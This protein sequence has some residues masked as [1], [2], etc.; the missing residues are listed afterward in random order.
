M[1]S[2]SSVLS[3][4]RLSI[5]PI[6]DHE[7]WDLY[8]KHLSS[9]W[10]AEECD[11]GTDYKDFQKMKPGE[12]RFI[13]MVL[14]FFNS[15]D[16]IVNKNLAANFLNEPEFQ[17]PEIQFFY[18]FQ[19]MMENIHSTTYS[20]LID[21]FFKDK[22]E[23]A[24][25]FDAIANF[26]TIRAKAEWVESYMNRDK[27][28][29]NRLFGFALCEGLSFSGS[30]C[31]IYWLKKRNLCHGLTFTNELISKDEGLHT[32]FSCLMFKRENAKL[33]KEKRMTQEEA[34]KIT[35]EC[36]EVENRFVNESL[37]ISLIGM[38]S[39]MMRQYIEF[40]ADFICELA[41]FE[42]I[43]GTQN[44]FPFMEMIS[45]E[46]RTNFF[47]KRVSE[48]N[49]AGVGNTAEQQEFCLDAEF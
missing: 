42:R 2:S 10:T 26:P 8:Q 6:Q 22:E 17:E 43:Y 23:K 28:L 45:L 46:G 14:A 32:Q 21:T 35:R 33:P 47:E 36:V 48:Y 3:G 38:N 18:W 20:L 41:G 37:K 30:F 1:S 4:Q 13:K 11:L 9:F 5:L 15:A 12:Q 29:V 49:K 19:G 27:P 16:L 34:H 31:A 25:A 40:V 44:P 7:V 39:Q 24:K